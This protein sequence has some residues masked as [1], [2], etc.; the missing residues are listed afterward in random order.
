MEVVFDLE[1]DGLLSGLTKL[2]VW[3]YVAL[4]DPVW[5]GDVPSYWAPEGPETIPHKDHKKGAFETC[6]SA[7]VLIGHNIIG[8]DLQAL[9]KL[10]P[11]WCPQG[12]IRDTMIYSYLLY[13]DLLDYDI[14][15]STKHGGEWIPKNLWGKHSL[16]AWGFRL[17]I[18]K[19]VY[20]G[21]WEEYNEDMLSYCIQDVIVTRHLWERFK[22]EAK[23]K[24]TEDAIVL[25]H[26]MAE[27][28]SRMEQHGWLLDVPAAHQLTGKLLARKEELVRE[29]QDKYFPPVFKPGK[30]FTP[31]RDNKT[32]GYVAGVPFCKVELQDFNPGSRQQI[33]SRLQKQYGW[34][35][36]E[37]TDPTEAHPEGQVEVSEDILA[38]LDYPCC[39]TLAEYLKIEK[40]LGFLAEG[41]NSLLTHVDTDSRIRGRVKTCGTQTRRASHSSPNVAQTPAVGILYGK[42]IRSL[43]IVPKGKR[44]VGCDADGL[45]ARV[46]AHFM[47]PYDNGEFAWRVVEG[48]KEDKTDIHSVNQGLLKFKKRDN[49]KTWIYALIYGAG[50]FKLG[51]ICLEDMGEDAK[52]SI[53]NEGAIKRLGK[54]SREAVMAGLPALKELLEDIKRTA[55]SRG[56]LKA[57]DGARLSIRSE[58]AAPNTLFQSAG[59]LVMKR[60][61]LIL[62]EKCLD[63]RWEFGK[64]WA[65][66]GWIH[67]EFQLEVDEDK[68]ELIGK[69]AAD[70]IKEAGDYYGFLCPLAG[71][72]SVGLNWAETH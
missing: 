55:K 59:A 18:L 58:H 45:E 44:Q 56:W 66:V 29:L 5:D 35:P 2:H 3:A 71:N 31:A 64:E 37:F 4:P 24:L 48:K 17:G 68:A 1:T 54:E 63:L 33:A 61:A 67:D 46:T 10:Y 65:L 20:T 23:E 36:I 25:E 42:E 60:A 43:F 62:D 32:R 14:M 21:G 72:Y 53:T 57:L 40:R 52:H 9:K 15:E 51:T 47:Y 6:G 69:M 28:C 70:S 7:D 49:A 41:D 16:E 30:E 11:E 50:D 34:K 19:G 13:P 27:L 8:F 39:P 38:G 12:N 26:R 22:T